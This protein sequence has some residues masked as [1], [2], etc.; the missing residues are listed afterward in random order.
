M[1]NLTV[2]DFINNRDAYLENGRSS[3]GS[4]AQERFREQYREDMID[5]LMEEDGLSYD[6]AEARTND[7]M[8]DKAALHDPDQIAGG[9]GDNVTGLG[10]G[11]VNSSLGSQWKT[12]ID[13]IDA[14]VR[15]QSANMTPEQRANTYLNITLPWQ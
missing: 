1:N 5:R 6:D 3:E 10:N 13:A 15:E 14:Q 12:R 2:E 9:H 11:R 7:F 4:A 8:S